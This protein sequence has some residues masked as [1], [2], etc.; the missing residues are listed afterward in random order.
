MVQ[1]QAHN[2]HWVDHVSYTLLAPEAF[3]LCY[4]EVRKWESSFET[5][6]IFPKM[7]LLQ[8]LHMCYIHPTCIAPPQTWISMFTDAS[9]II[10]IIIIIITN[11]II[12]III[13]VKNISH[14]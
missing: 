1:S 5:L 14:K 3:Y 10:I 9:I 6:R 12:I 4:D 13:V 2:V 7:W 11:I 8:F